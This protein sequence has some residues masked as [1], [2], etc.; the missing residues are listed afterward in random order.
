MAT[1]QVTAAVALVKSVNPGYT[2]NQSVSSL[3]RAA[4][5]PE[6]CENAYYGSRYLNPLLAVTN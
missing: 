2:A 4:D 6:G 1:P 5:V 3:K